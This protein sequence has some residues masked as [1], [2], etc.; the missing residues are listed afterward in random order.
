LSPSTHVF[1]TGT[2]PSTHVSITVPRN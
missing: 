2:P 1:V